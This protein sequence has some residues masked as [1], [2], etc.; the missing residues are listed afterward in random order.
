MTKFETFFWHC[1]TLT[2]MGVKP[3]QEPVKKMVVLLHGY[4]GDAP[5]NMEFARK[6]A[7]ACPQTVVLVPNGPTP[8]PP[9]NDPQHRQWYPLPATAD[10]DG[11]F[12]SFMPCYAP[13]EK[14]MQMRESTPHI[15]K[16]AKLLNSFILEQIK[17][18]GLSLSDCFLAGISQGGITAFDMVLF[19]KELRKNK[20][21]N[22]LG[23][24]IVIGAGIN[25]SDRLNALKLNDF[26][27]IPVLL[28][29]GE[30]DEIF[31]KTVDYFSAAQLRLHRLPVETASA[32][33]GHFG[34]EHKVCG[35][36][37]RFIREHS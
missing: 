10:S 14:Q 27:P 20:T 25:E 2:G 13:A 24:L 36:V 31:P 9:Q 5:S 4:M 16:T 1:R 6:I 22:F 26:P 7:A 12:Y 15:Q 19:R 18:Y 17:E 35:A 8:V 34:L 28:A 23:G 21:K 29:R 11:Y 33:S 30:H 3:D 37:C 32:D